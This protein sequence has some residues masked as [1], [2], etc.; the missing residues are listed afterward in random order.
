M[1]VKFRQR[2]YCLFVLTLLVTFNLAA[3]AQPPKTVPALFVSDIHFDPFHDPDLVKQLNAAPAA[4]WPKIL[5]APA[6]ASQQ[7][8]FESLQQTCH[9]RGVDTP[10]AL[11]DSALHA[12]HSRLPGAK[13]ITV[14]GDLIAHAF[15]CRYSTLFPNSTPAEYQAFV[16]KTIT[17]VVGQLRATFPGI[18]VYTA[19]GNN[20]SSCGDYKLDANSAFFALTAPIF[21]DVLPASQRKH[22][23]EDFKPGG[24]Y[25]VSMAEPMRNTRLI[26]LNDNLGSPKHTTCAGQPDPAPAAAEID[27]LQSQLAAARAAHQ[28]V[29]VIGHIP[30]GVDPYSTVAKMRNV[31]AG[32][33]PSE[34][35]ANDQLADS[36]VRSA[37]IIRLGIFGHTHMDEMRLVTSETGTAQVPLKVVP[38]IS[39]VDGNIPAF[40]VARINPATAT[41]A[42]Y[43]VLQ[44]SNQ[45]GIATTWSLE[46]NY[47]ATY[48][49]PDYS[50]ASVAQLIAGFHA[51]RSATNPMSIAYI[52]NY[53][54]GDMSG[55]I[56]PFWPEYVCALD[57]YSEKSFAAC[58]CAS[59]K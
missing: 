17:Y 13:F 22:A 25:S 19:L 52:H 33:S 53:F 3:Q 1:P 16:L 23:I 31:C 56:S 46:Y 59:A 20:D 36:L 18:P 2:L 12:M 41:L 8:A 4:E 37:D 28:R 5:A 10:Y 45:T 30:T 9:A 29:W 21:A 58:V 50:P 42:D 7:T 38:S 57:N 39:P 54:V 27:W 43:D 48:H 47:A 26:A 35:L 49:Q 40:T 44:A 55:E 15:T 32:K 14:S 11:F 24:Y 6:S 34:F 51:D